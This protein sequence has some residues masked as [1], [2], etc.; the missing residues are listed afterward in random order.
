MASDFFE[1]FVHKQQYLFAM[2]FD[3]YLDIFFE[4]VIAG[5]EFVLRIKKTA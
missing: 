3:S 1:I 2:A 4:P 5:E